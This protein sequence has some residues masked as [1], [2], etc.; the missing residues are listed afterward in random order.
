LVE[1]SFLFLF[2][3]PYSGFVVVEGRTTGW[4]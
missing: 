3:D 1:P 2:G 4:L